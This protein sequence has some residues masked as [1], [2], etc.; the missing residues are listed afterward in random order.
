MVKKCLNCGEV[1]T[2]SILNFGSIPITSLLSN[3]ESFTLN[4]EKCE[5]CFIVFTINSLPRN[6]LYGKDYNFF[7]STSNAYIAYTKKIIST[8]ESIVNINECD[9]LEIG[10]NDGVL[11]HQI[12]SKVKSVVGID[13]FFLATESFNDNNNKATI[14][15]DYFNNDAVKNYNLNEKFDVVI[16]NNVITHVDDVFDFIKALSLV[17][18]KNGIIYFEMCDYKKV[19]ENDRFDYFYHGVTNLI[20][21]NQI[22]RLLKGFECIK[23]YGFDGFDPFSNKF[24][25]Q[26][27]N[28]NI[29]NY[30]FPNDQI[31]SAQLQLDSWCK[32]INIFFNNLSNFKKVVGYGANS[33]SGIVFALSPIAKQKIDVILDI[34]LNKHNKIISG[35]SVQIKHI[36]RYDISEIDCIVLFA[37][38][39]FEEVEHALTIRGYTGK[40]LMMEL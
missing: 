17:V 39:I 8:I 28:S 10:C 33:K 30:N 22:E 18:K 40:L 11:M 31:N 21:P 16:V 19:I 38:H 36:D 23:D 7:S 12:E 5:K 29:E 4:Y 35:S 9:V 6:I 15:N 37:S 27:T 3:K 1:K 14:I 34:N 20:L 2:Q 25:L 26:K 13:P 32:K 24:I